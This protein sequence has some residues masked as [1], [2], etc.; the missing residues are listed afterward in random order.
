MRRLRVIPG[1]IPGGGTSDMQVHDKHII[2]RLKREHSILNI[3]ARR[4]KYQR[5]L[6]R[7]QGAMGTSAPARIPIPKLTR[8]EH[9][10]NLVKAWEKV[11]VGDLHSLLPDVKVMPYELAVTK[12]W[13]PENAFADFET[14]IQKEQEQDDAAVF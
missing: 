3:R 8:I 6:H 14:I 12:G 5:A 2:K 4:Q 7:L 13:T 9:Y 1:I 11:D 10:Q